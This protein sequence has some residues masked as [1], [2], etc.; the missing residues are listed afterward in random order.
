MRRRKRQRK[1]KARLAK[2]RVDRGKTAAAPKPA[3]KKSAAA[4]K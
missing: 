4:K 2:K 3:K 1:L